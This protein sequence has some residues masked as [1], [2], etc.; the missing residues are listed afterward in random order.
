MSDSKDTNTLKAT[1]SANLN[2][3]LEVADMN[4]ADLAAALSIPF[5]TVADW[6]HGRKYP[7]MDK[8]QAIADY[9]G[10]LKSDLT[11]ERSPLPPNAIPIDLS[12][13]RRIPI[14]G[15]ISAGLPLYAEEHI[16]GYTITDLNGGAEYFGLRVHGDS[17]NAL[18]IN[19]GDIIIARRQEEVEQ[20]EIAVVL[21]DEQDATVKR[22]Y[23]SDTTVT[24]MPQSTNPEHKPQMYDLSKTLVRVLGKVVKV[25]FIV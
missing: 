21:V 25:E 14:L 10:I 15:R 5:S 20:G 17:M 18:R 23:S 22:F 11:E 3:Y 6:V 2:H 16:E 9:F 19:E 12:K 13:F 4:I 7:R 8:V 24:L 1:F